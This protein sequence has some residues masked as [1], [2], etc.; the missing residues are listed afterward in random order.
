MEQNK[1]PFQPDFAQ[2][3]YEELALHGEYTDLYILKPAPP[4]SAAER[5]IEAIDPLGG[6]GISRIKA[7][8]LERT[9]FVEE[10]ESR[11]M[12]IGR[13]I[14]GLVWSSKGQPKTY[15]EKLVEE[16]RKGRNE[17]CMVGMGRIGDQEV[18]MLVYNWKFFAGSIGMVAGEKY[19]QAVDLALKKHIPFLAV[20]STS[21]VR[22]QENFAGLE[23]MPRMISALTEYQEKSPH[24]HVGLLLG[25]VWGGASAS[26]VPLADVTVAFAGT[27][28]G[29]SGPNVIETYE[30]KP[31]PK[32]AQRAEVHA[33]Q[34]SVDVIVNSVDDAVDFTERLYTATKKISPNKLDESH[35]LPLPEDEPTFEP[36][37]FDFEHQ[38][39]SPLARGV[40]RA[41][42]AYRHPEEPK[43]EPR[44]PSPKPTP[45]ELY[46][47]YQN[48]LRS[49]ERPDAEYFMQQVFTDT[50]PLYNHYN[51][52]EVKH[53]PAIIASIGRLG[54]Q[55]CLIIGSQPS[56]QLS[57]DEV[58][59]IPSSPSPQDYEYQ[60]RMLNMGE[61]LNL[62]V[63]Y[64]CD[65][66]GA[67]PTLQAEM[68]NQMY[69]IA[70][71]IQ[72]GITYKHSELAINIGA[73]G[74]GG[75]LTVAPTGDYIG[76]LQDSMAFVA[77]PQSATSI[78]QKEANPKRQQVM[79]T[80]ASMG[81]TAQEQF[82]HGLINEVIPESKDRNHTAV[83][84][85]N[86]LVRA[87]I[88]VQD[89]SPRQR[90]Q[91]RNFH[92]R[93]L[94]PVELV[95]EIADGRAE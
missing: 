19:Q 14:I 79:T 51:L 74:S 67:K 64:F 20:Y 94:R 71:A 68:N 84:V 18:S 48:L 69:K 90:K 82:D 72:R 89:L 60:Q 3:L 21:G 88:R 43:P 76:M 42:H 26:T 75:G 32:G 11:L 24:P 65:T 53:Y 61:R 34:R 40:R 77:E 4:M 35:L 86:A 85:Q 27:E 28:Y 8:F 55:P 70:A 17:S 13:D 83:F 1:R 12:R 91:R 49:S 9:N 45:E 95:S 81:A 6:E 80:V 7:E 5:I 50:V 38:G 23:Q 22:Q 78:L 2:D 93:N 73:L 16:A 52:G 62:P 30:G 47:R 58:R 15:P 46:Q 25:Q 63:V 10:R 33:L 92:L 31:V 39:F 57:G 37:I 59:K 29:F 44:K 87:M 54:P 66:L 56:Y 41:I 36:R